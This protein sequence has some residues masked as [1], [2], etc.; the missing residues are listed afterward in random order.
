[1]RCSDIM[2]S[3]V[4]CLNLHD[5]A[6]T[7]ARAMQDFNIGFLPVCD[8]QRRVV[9][10]VT[11]RDLALRVLGTNLTAATPVTE[12]MTREVVSCGPD[13]DLHA[14]EQQMASRRKSRLLIIDDGGRLCGVIS[15]SDIAQFEKSAR[16]ADTM[17]KVSER[18]ARPA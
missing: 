14:A 17:R 4:K 10:T 9:G 3:D 18:E 13:D 12:V 16:A 2:K 8:P 5:T 6:H 15:L 7:A 11:D 1:M